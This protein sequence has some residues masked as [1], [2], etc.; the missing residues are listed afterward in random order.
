[1]AGCASPLTAGTKGQQLASQLGALAPPPRHTPVRMCCSTWRKHPQVPQA[2]E[3]GWGSE[4]SGA[5]TLLHSDLAKAPFWLP[6]E[7]AAGQPRVWKAGVTSGSR[8]WADRA[9]AEAAAVRFHGAEALAARRA[10]LEDRR[11]QAAGEGGAGGS[12]GRRRGAVLLLHGAGDSG[13]AIL[14]WCIECGMAAALSTRGL[15]LHAPDAPWRRFSPAGG[16]RWRVWFDR[17]PRG[18]D[19]E[20]HVARA[21]ELVAAE[22]G[23]VCPVGGV[24]FVVG[25]S[26]G[27]AIG[28][29][30]ALRGSLD[31]LGGGGRNGRLGGVAVMSGWIDRG[32]PSYSALQGR[33]EGKPS[34]DVLLLHGGRDD[35]VPSV[36][37]Q[38]NEHQL[39]ALSPAD[40]SVHIRRVMMPDLGH[41]VTPEEIGLLV[42]WLDSRLRCI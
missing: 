25:F 3:A 14:S 4:W 26:Q 6:V 18:G 15:T 1:M 27:G 35:L 29:H 20:E 5:S 41:E 9:Q 40:G 37:V 11:R 21:C 22:A 42:Q 16:E 23:R 10:A 38:R 17:P 28:L 32:T 8:L 39:R 12:A 36:W 13:A 24:V 34:L 2:D 31:G 7:L 19:N 30:C 33:G